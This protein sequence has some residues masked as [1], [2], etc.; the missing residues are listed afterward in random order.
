MKVRQVLHAKETPF[1]IGGIL[2]VMIGAIL[3]L[4]LT[5]DRPLVTTP[6]I[7]QSI[8][9]G[10]LFTPY[11][12]TWL[13]DGYSV[14]ATSYSS[15]GDALVFVAIKPQADPITFSQQAV[16]KNFDMDGFLKSSVT[17]TSRLD[18]TDYPAVFGKM[19]GRRQ[20]MASITADT[21]WILLTLPESLTKGDAKQLVNHLVRQ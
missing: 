17:D 12:P 14:D 11:V 7:P 21:T 5:V 15:E 8:N 1:V 6:Y 16:P 10:L 18:S 3:I 20:N 9:S 2:V 19:N 13:P 4:R